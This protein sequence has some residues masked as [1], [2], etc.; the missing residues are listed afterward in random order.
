MI[1]DAFPKRLMVA[2][3]G[4]G[5]S[6]CLHGHSGWTGLDHG[7]TLDSDHLANYVPDN[8]A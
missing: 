2:H 8:Q 7:Y 4:A 5:L 3:E 1:A 6:A